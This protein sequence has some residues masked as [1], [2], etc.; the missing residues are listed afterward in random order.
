MFRKKSINRSIQS[1]DQ[2][3]Q[4][5]DQS[6]QSIKSIRP[7]DQSL[8]ESLQLGIAAGYTGRSLKEIESTLNRIESLMVTKDWFK[9]EFQDNTPQIM[10][11]LQFIRQLLEEH[12]ANEQ[13]RFDYIQEA[14]QN[15]SETAK[16][17][18]E[19]IKTELLTQIQA[20]ES[21][22]PLTPRMRELITI[23]KQYGE[24]SY[25]DLSNLLNITEDRLR[26]LLST[27]VRRT[28]QIERFEKQGRGW[29]RFKADRITQ[30]IT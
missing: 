9:T 10:E 29:V 23:V 8:T 20:I 18:P 14:L 7:I 4:S 11:T 15:L 6:R 19:P 26:G 5:E 21:K 2:S 12:E 22:L 28:D 25:T 16:I 1:E 27:T 3:I 17:A 13:R 30:S 24:I